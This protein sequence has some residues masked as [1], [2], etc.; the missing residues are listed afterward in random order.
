[1][2]YKVFVSYSTDDL[3]IVNHLRALLAD[4][5]IEVYIAEYSALPGTVLDQSIIAAIEA[6]D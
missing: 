6:C 2:A 1:M 3:H 5:S 4:A